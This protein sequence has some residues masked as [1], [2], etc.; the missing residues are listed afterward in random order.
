MRR[1][2]FAIIA[3]VSLMLN[4]NAT[5]SVVAKTPLLSGKYRLF[6]CVGYVYF[7]FVSYNPFER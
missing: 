5:S 7:S 6:A 1:S 2:A 4:F 3:V